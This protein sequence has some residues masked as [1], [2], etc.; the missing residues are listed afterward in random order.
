M[1][2]YVSYLSLV[3]L[4]SFLCKKCGKW[5]DETEFI[6]LQFDTIL[7]GGDSWK[8]SRKYYLH[9]QIKREIYWNNFIMSK[10]C[11]NSRKVSFQHQMSKDC[12]G[13]VVTSQ[14]Y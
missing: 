7:K 9:T 12:H 4:G 13:F 8:T 10:I 5:V 2:C 1:K 11:M 3:G 6:T 14:I